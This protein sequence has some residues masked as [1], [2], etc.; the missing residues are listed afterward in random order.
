MSAVTTRRLPRLWWLGAA[1]L[2]LLA[3]LGLAALLRRRQP[4]S[5]VTRRSTP[6]GWA[7]ALRSTAGW[8][9]SPR[10]ATRW[11]AGAGPAHRGRAHAFASLIAAETFSTCLAVALEMCSPR[12]RS[13]PG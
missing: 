10:A 12:M 6:P 2:V 9:A 1:V 7:A 3:M 11:R 5:A 4:R 13:S 8:A